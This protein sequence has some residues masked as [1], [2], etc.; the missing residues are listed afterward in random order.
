M[1]GEKYAM[2]GPFLEVGAAPGPNSILAGPYFQGKPDRVGLNLRNNEMLDDHSGHPITFHQCN[3]ND[4]RGQFADGHFTTVLS[5]AVIEHDKYFWRSL[6]EMKRVLA[7][8]GIMAVGAPGYIAGKFVKKG[9]LDETAKN[10]T[11]TLDLHAPPDYW[12][13]SR[14][15]F[16][17]VIC[18][19]LELLELSVINR[20]PIIIAVAR[21]PLTGLLPT[22]PAAL[23]HK[24][25]QPDEED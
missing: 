5:N 16:K 10:A 4:M 1:L 13:F 11:I 9:L 12:R 18:E 8:G 7:P 6:D 19:G 22:A 25:G 3:S 20:I 23:I 2:K 14:A 24:P 21:K 15:A 17:D